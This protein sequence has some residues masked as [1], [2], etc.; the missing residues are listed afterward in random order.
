MAMGQLASRI[1][2]GYMCSCVSQPWLSF[3]FFFL[4]FVL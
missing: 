3:F 2:M 1:S 4:L